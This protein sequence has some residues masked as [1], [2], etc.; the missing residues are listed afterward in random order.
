MARG[1][2]GNTCLAL[3]NGARGAFTRAASTSSRL[4]P[5]CSRV[6][7]GI[8]LLS[9]AFSWFTGRSSKLLRERAPL[10]ACDGLLRAPTGPPPISFTPW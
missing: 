4:S 10:R 9:K 7:I 6:V 5:S 1:I 3:V 2:H 8:A